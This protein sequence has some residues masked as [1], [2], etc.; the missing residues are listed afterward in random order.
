[1]TTAAPLAAAAP[2]LADVQ[3]DLAWTVSCR[4]LHQQQTFASAVLHVQGQWVAPMLG[5]GTLLPDSVP[6]CATLVTG[7]QRQPVALPA[8]LRAVVE[9]RAGWTHLEIADETQVLLRASFEGGRLVYC[10]GDL[11]A[12]AGLQAATY[13]APTGTLDVMPH[14]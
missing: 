8:T 4:A 9:C 1:M 6:L 3:L 14:A 11:P 10:T 5:H 13:E 2:K 12:R 7:P